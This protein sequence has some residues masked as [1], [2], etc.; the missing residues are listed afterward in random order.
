MRY[1]FQIDGSDEPI[2]LITEDVINFNK[3]DIVNV[4]FRSTDKK[5]HRIRSV[6]YDLDQWCRN[7]RKEICLDKTTIYL[8]EI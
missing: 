5:K 1:E 3:G 4:T 2:E 6:E 7:G 8:E